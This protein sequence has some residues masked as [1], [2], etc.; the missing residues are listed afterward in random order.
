MGQSLDDLPKYRVNRWL[1]EI[2]E[3][4]KHTDL[5]YEIDVDRYDDASD[6]IAA[7]M[8]KALSSSGLTYDVYVTV[9]VYNGDAKDY[10]PADN[11]GAED[12]RDY[13]DFDKNATLVEFDRRF[14]Y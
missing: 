2:R 6:D 14:H 9:T 10:M 3:H 5:I 1:D 4:F 11:F 12:V 13:Y 8:L 7:N